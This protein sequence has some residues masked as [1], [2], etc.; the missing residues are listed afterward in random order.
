MNLI[1]ANYAD[2]LAEVKT[3]IK[4]SQAKAALSVNTALIAMN[5]NI[6]AMIAANQALYQTENCEKIAEA[7]TK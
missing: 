7:R 4:S 6:G 3:Q 5:W 1:K 2:F